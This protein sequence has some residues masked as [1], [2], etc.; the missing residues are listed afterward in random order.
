V[1]DWDVR[2]DELASDAIRAGEPT[3]WFDR[4]YS[5]GERGEVSMPWDRRA[6]MAVLEA[7]A[8]SQRLTGDGRRAVVVG[9]GLGAD[10]EF[11]SSLG[12]AVTAFD[13]SA[14]AVRL[15]AQRNPGSTVDYRQAD[16]LDLPSELLGAFDL[17]V[18]IFTLQAL[19]DPPRAQAIRGV[20]SLVAAGGTLFAVAFR[21]DDAS[22]AKNGPPFALSRGTVQALAGDTLDIAEIVPVDPGL[23][24]A[25]LRDPRP[26]A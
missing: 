7:W 11:L 2:G 17:V 13:V 25:V 10:A 16:L 14:T 18:E 15:A 19:P 9:C 20:T 6:P 26:P 24:R 4:L 23:W 8:G 12:F 1:R 21:T 5:E 3:A 22:D